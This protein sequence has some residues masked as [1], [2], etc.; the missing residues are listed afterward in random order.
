MLVANPMPDWS[1]EEI[2]GVHFRMHNAEGVLSRF[3]DTMK[4]EVKKAVKV[5]VQ[6]ARDAQDAQQ[7]KASPPR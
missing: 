7:V 6:D 2:P 3:K 1:I 4:K 5:A